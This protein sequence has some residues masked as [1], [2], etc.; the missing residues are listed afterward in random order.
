MGTTTASCQFLRGKTRRH[1]VIDDFRTMFFVRV[2]GLNFFLDVSRRIP[3]DESATWTT[4]KKWFERSRK[5]GTDENY[6]Q[7]TNGSC[8]K[9]KKLVQ[10]VSGRVGRGIARDW[11]VFREGHYGFE[12]LRSARP[13]VAFSCC[14]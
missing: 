3:V 4:E 7:R 11:G 9:F 13:L 1:K 5:I 6:Q 2:C 10:E 8:A 14:N 12:E